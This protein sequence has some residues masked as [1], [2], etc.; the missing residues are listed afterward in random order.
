MNG[1][2]VCVLRIVARLPG[3]INR[4]SG[5]KKRGF[6]RNPVITL[7]DRVCEFLDAA[8]ARHRYLYQIF[9]MIWESLP[10]VFILLETV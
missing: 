1:S 5:W 6:V 10:G 4:S 8:S 9:T 7:Q 3:E 2:I